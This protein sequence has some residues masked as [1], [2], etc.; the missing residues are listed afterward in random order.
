MK[1]YSE[2]VKYLAEK[3]ARDYKM[4]HFNFTYFN[5][6]VK[7]ISTIFDVGGGTVTRDVERELQRI[8]KK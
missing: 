2:S 7:C 8:M 4:E 6:W 5:E 3:T 1:T